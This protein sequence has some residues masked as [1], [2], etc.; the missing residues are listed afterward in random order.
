MSTSTEQPFPIPP[1]LLEI[2]QRDKATI[3]ANPGSITKQSMITY[4]CACGN[5][6]EKMYNNILNTGTRCKDCT[7]AIR[8]EKFK[9]TNLERFG[10]EYPMQ[11][12]NIVNKRIQ[13]IVENIGVSSHMKLPEFLEKKART[14]MER[15]GTPHPVKS[16]VIQEKRKQT[17]SEREDRGFWSRQR[18]ETTTT[19]NNFEK[20]GLITSVHQINNPSG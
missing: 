17:I 15:F 16:K 11:N 12:K 13:T 20:I 1:K 10:V 14:N 2:L 5:Q 8:I 9:Q 6:G 18:K 7:R 3:L 4:M 19:F